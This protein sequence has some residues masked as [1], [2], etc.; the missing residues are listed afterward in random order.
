MGL[1]C[2]QRDLSADPV[3]Q[4]EEL[5]VVPAILELAS[6]LMVSSAPM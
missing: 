5:A 6:E 4:A 1:K 2:F 3:R